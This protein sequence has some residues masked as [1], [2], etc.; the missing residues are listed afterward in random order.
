MSK[1]KVYHSWYQWVPLYYIAVAAAYYIPY[2]VLKTTSEKPHINHSNHNS[3]HSNF[4]QTITDY[5]IL[6]FSSILL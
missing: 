6:D 1:D 4:T 3:N 5:R 2:L